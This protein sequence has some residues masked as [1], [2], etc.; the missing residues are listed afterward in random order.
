MQT[1]NEIRESITIRLV[2]ALQSGTSKIPWRRPWRTVG[3]RLPTNHVTGRTYAG[4]NILSLWL[5][6]QERNFP[7]DLWASFNQWKSIGASV[8]KGA[9]SER[10]VFYSPIKKRKKD[11]NGVEKV[12]T[13]PILKTWSVFNIAEVEGKAVEKFHAQPA[14]VKFAEPDRE[15]FDRAVAATGATL[16]FGGDRAFY[17]RLPDDYVQIPNEDRFH[18]FAGYAETVGH[19]LLHWSEHRVGW[20]E[21]YA[22]SELR[23]EIGACFLSAALGIPDSGDLTNHGKYLASWLEALQSDHRFIF[24]ASSAASRGVDF[25]LAFSRPTEESGVESEAEAVAV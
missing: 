22:L 16:H 3:P 23:A 14:A 2:A 12:E 20:S 15:E 19:E 9:K 6:A 17:K 5:A 24:R 21:N 10:I 8:K 18:S 4:I 25:L 13:F 11:E 1:Q 7:V